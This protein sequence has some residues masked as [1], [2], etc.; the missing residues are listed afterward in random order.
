MPE[1]F[2][3][4]S[5]MHKIIMVFG[6]LLLLF[7]VTQI[8]GF[9]TGLFIIEDARHNEIISGL[10][11]K[12][13]EVN[14]FQLFLYILL[15]SFLMY[16]L[17]KF[18][19]AE[20]LFVLLEFGVISFS[21]SIV[22]YSV[23]K[24]LIMETQ[25]SV[26]ISVALGL[27]FAFLKIVFPVFRNLAAVIATAG[28]GAVFGFSLTFY[29]ALIFLILLSIYDYIAVFKTKHMV[30][31]ARLFSER[32]TCFM[33]SSSQKTEKGE[34]RLELGTGDM[35]LP[36]ILEISGFQ[37]NPIYSAII[38]VASVFSLF[39]LFV[40]LA[41]KKVTL[42]ALPIIAICNLVFLGIAKISGII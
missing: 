39:V 5:I 40:L 18:Y 28:A 1:K 20:L 42:P 8:I 12:N 22:F 19:K 7:I 34:I 17:V 32:K 38:F 4:N 6:Y 35:L 27:A 16:L 10:I 37:I 14:I 24:P 31:L 11:Q 3:Q 29:N 2:N 13:T 23:L 25:F 21:S 36:I 41:K 33:V 26:I 9:Y 15:A 30:E